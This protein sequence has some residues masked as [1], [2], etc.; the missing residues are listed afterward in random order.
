MTRRT[1]SGR[2]GAPSRATASSRRIEDGVGGVGAGAAPVIFCYSGRVSRLV[3]D[4]GATSQYA[5]AGDGLRSVAGCVS[6]GAEEVSDC[7]VPDAR[8]VLLFFD[9]RR[10]RARYRRGWRATILAMEAGLCVKSRSSKPGA[11]CG[12]DGPGRPR[13]RYIAGRTATSYFSEISPLPC[14]RLPSLRVA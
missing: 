9:V 8:G 14:L 4:A 7:G 2:Y 6:L 12:E 5:D 10:S 1:R 11:V 13:R 3:M